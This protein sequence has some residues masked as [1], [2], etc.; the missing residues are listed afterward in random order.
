MQ[1]FVAD[2]NQGIEI[3]YLPAYAPELNP[4]EQVWNQAKRKLGQQFAASRDELKRLAT[5][6]LR[7]I[8]KRID[9]VKSFFRL[10]TTEYILNIR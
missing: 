8:Q 7:S 3:G 5:N 6:A 1:R 2:P 10:P 9:L 4:D